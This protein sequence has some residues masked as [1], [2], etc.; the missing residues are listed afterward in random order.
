MFR[1]IRMDPT[2]CLQVAIKTLQF[3]EHDRVCARYRLDTWSMDPTRDI[4]GSHVWNTWVSWWNSVIIPPTCNWIFTSCDHFWLPRGKT[5]TRQQWGQH[6]PWNLSWECNNV[7]NWRSMWNLKFAV[8]A[9]FSKRVFFGDLL[10]HLLCELL[11]QFLYRDGTCG[12]KTGKVG[13]YRTWPSW[14]KNWT[15][16]RTENVEVNP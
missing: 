8:T 1:P 15:I 10:L 9:D 7:T 4:R 11:S 12:T 14:Y 16:I 6:S 2:N 3:T 5:G 13:S